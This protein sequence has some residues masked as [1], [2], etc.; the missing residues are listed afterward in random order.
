MNEGTRGGR[1]VLLYC[2]F[3]REIRSG[4]LQSSSTMNPDWLAAQLSRDS[5]ELKTSQIVLTGSQA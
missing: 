1:R 5:L 3:F 2:M 4:K